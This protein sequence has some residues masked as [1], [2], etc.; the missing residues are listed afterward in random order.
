MKYRAR[1]E[2]QAR[3]TACFAV[4]VKMLVALLLSLKELGPCPI[5]GGLSTPAM[6]PPVPL[7]PAALQNRECMSCA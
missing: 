6:V 7:V 5:T 2:Q 3:I 1:R 4:P